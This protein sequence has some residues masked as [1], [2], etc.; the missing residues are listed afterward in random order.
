MSIDRDDHIK[1]YALYIIRLSPGEP[2]CMAYELTQKGNIRLE[3]KFKSP[4]TS[5]VTA[6]VY[7]EYDDQLEIDHDR[8]VMIDV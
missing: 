8:N 6:I 3:M 5:T 7:V 1:G 4:L 2:D